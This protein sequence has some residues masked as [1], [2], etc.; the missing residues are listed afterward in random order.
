LSGH[1]YLEKNLFDVVV[2]LNYLMNDLLDHIMI[3]LFGL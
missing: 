3:A 2:V 1:E